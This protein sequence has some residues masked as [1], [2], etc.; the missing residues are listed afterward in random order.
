MGAFLL[1]LWRAVR[2]L[3]RAPRFAL[4]ALLTLSLGIG[5]TT[6]LFSV[7]HA[8]LLRP[9][10]YREPDRLVALVEREVTSG[11]LGSLSAPDFRDLREGS[12]SLEAVAIWRPRGLEHAGGARPERIR[13]LETSAGHLDAVLG[14]RPALGRFFGPEDESGAA[15]VVL[16]H[17]F[18]LRA[19]GGDPSVVGRSLRLDG[20]DRTVVGVAPAGALLP[21][22]P[23]GDVLVPLDWRTSPARDRGDHT[24]RGIGR[25]RPGVEAVAATAELT[26][27]TNALADRFPDEVR[28]DWPKVA[29]DLRESLVGDRALSLLLLMG[30]A[31]T[32]LLVACTNVASLFMARALGRSRET[33]IRITLGSPTR[34][35][36][37]AFLAEGLALSAAAGLL[38]LGL[39]AVVIRA[40]PLWLPGASELSAV[41]PIR[42]DGTG[43]GFA[44]LLALATSAFFALAPLVQVRRLDLQ[45]ELEDGGRAAS[46]GKGLLRTGLVAG[47]V[48]AT[49]LLLVTSLLLLSSLTKVM[50]TAPGF[51]TR[52]L[53]TF[54]LRLPGGRYASEDAA[55]ALQAGL[56]ERLGVLPGVGSMG[57]TCEPPLTGVDDDTGFALADEARAIPPSQW[58]SAERDQVGGRY[59]ETMGIRI[60]KGRALDERD[61]AGS[62]RV[63]VVS[64]SLARRHV[65]GDPLGRRLVHGQ[66][67][68]ASPAGTAFEI[69]GVAADIRNGALERPPA[70]RIYM[71]YAQVPRPHLSV[72]LRTSLPPRALRSAVESAISE[73]DPLLPVGPLDS[74]EERARESAADRRQSILLL[75]GFTVLALLL[76]AAGIYGVV[77]YIVVQRRREFGI[78]VSLGARGAQIATLVVGEGLRAVLL[79]AAIGLAASVAGGRVLASHLY[80]VTA[81]DPLALGAAVVTLVAVSLLACALPALRAMSVD[82]AAVLR[83]P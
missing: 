43:A 55:R 76:S 47:E 75:G 25:L 24:Y 17:G 42:V 70:P 60:L 41:G 74:L 20:R 54:D 66:L 53:V 29:L 37:R 69:V 5:V 4:A 36:F 50:G 59:F 56:V 27:L 13:G 81:H 3:R 45:S 63:V 67:S 51:E 46:A 64:E 2:S 33:A 38:G 73:L 79:G 62:P 8:V 58:P 1:D 34:D 16:T 6:A 71:P 21:G 35:L 83:E 14:F 7:V 57:T 32:L 23:R 26:A 40:V 78:R 65:P 10:P 31:G 9:L 30:A 15:V 12:R 22:S 28:G 11:Q 18:W 80:G 77:S 61:T 48:A 52:N 82:P 39:S 44:S 72:V 49:T 19:F 68:G